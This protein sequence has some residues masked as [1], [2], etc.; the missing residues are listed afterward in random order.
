MKIKKL[1]LIGLLTAA[2]LIIF[3]VELQIPNPIPI[4]GIKL[5][6][7]N[8]ICVYA[9][10][11]LGSNAAFMILIC[12]IILGSIL[13]GQTAALIY[14]LSGGILCFFSM[15][16]MRKIVTINQLWVC[17]AVSAVFHN[18]GQMA[19]ALFI[20]KTPAILVYFPLL[21]ISGIIAGLFTG[22]CAQFLVKRL[23]HSPG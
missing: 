11:A 2:A 9:M 16:V 23:P 5:G 17:S 22:L 21:L 18:I 4:P 20:T 12:R 7:A 15:L 1:T 8:I 13:T 6:L 10:F 14:S 3:V 19:A